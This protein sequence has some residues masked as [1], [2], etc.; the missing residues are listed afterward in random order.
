MKVLSY[1][2]TFFVFGS[3]TPEQPANTVPN[4]TNSSDSTQT[5]Q[6]QIKM[7]DPVEMKSE[8]VLFLSHL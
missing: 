1:L 8:R 2:A 4:D 6:M 5:I 7:E 3:P